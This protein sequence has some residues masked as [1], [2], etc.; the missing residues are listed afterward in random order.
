[1]TRRS[2]RRMDNE[3]GWGEDA[4]GD[5]YDDGDEYLESEEDDYGN[6][7]EEEFYG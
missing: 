6:G 5:E 1:M 7:E 2:R 3:D 4:D